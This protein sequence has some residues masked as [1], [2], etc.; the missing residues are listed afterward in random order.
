MLSLLLIPVYTFL[1]ILLLFRITRRDRS[2]LSRRFVAGSF[3][4]KAGAG[5][6]YGYLFMHFYHG[7]DTWK[8]HDDA[9]VEYYKL[10]TE[11]KRFLTDTFSTASGSLSLG[12]AYDT[13]NS[14][15]S[16]FEEVLFTRLLVFFDLFS[17]GHYYVNV[18]FFSFLSYLGHLLLYRLLVRHH[19][20]SS[21]P[22]KG[23]IFFYPVVLFWVSGIQKEGLLL[24]G[25]AAAFYYTDKI[26]Q[27]QGRLYRNMMLLAGS[28]I[29]LWLIRN[30]VLLCMAPALLAWFLHGRMKIAKRMAFA[31][32]YGIAG[33]LFF[34]GHHIP[35]IPD[36]AQKVANRQYSFLSLTG[37][38]RLPL[39]SLQARP[40]AYLKVLPQALNHSFLQPL[41]TQ[42]KSI[43]Q[44]VSAFDIYLFFGSGVL[45]F[46]FRKS[47]W[48]QVLQDPLMLTLFCTAFAGYLIVGYIVPFPGAF[49][50]YKSLFEWL[51]V[52][53]FATGTDFRWKR[54]IMKN[55]ILKQKA[56][57]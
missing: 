36:L 41:I 43:L 53:G 20:D 24:V 54:E 45:A 44:L 48:K 28:L 27:E 21:F 13:N 40:G 38:T 26:I 9:F 39:D 56:K 3:L 52:A 1:L 12:A 46:L 5:I 7:M 51:F 30:L 29:M 19:P 49:V 16:D 50:R 55:S 2:F 11:P 17:F 23:A 25:M 6:L 10:L 22:L 18:M 32:V 57:V 33:I 4:V 8:Y 42:S 14:Y 35:G 31:G 47:G 15:W 34:W 37:N